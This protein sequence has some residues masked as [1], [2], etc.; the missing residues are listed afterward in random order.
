MSPAD[1]QL[2]LKER[3]LTMKKSVLK[4]VVPLFFLALFVTACG[5]SPDTEKMKQGLLKQ[6]VDAAQADCFVDA[7]KSAKGEAY[8]YMAEALIGGENVAKSMQRVRRK[9]GPDQKGKLDEARKACI[10]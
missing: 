7:A 2:N 10:Q 8:N 4:M 1:F 5:P 3:V 6:G 9:Y